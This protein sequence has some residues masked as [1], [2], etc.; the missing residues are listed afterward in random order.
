MRAGART[1]P[2]DAASERRRKFDTLFTTE[3]RYVCGTLRR[4]GVQ[5]RDVEDVAHEVFV[6]IFNKIDTFDVSRP[7][8]PWMLAFAYRAASEY[9]R[10]ARHRREESTGS[11]GRLERAAHATEPPEP[12]TTDDRAVVEEALA[13]VPLDR[14]VVLVAF[15]VDELPMKEIAEGLGIPLAT[16]YSR[17]RHARQD[18]G[19]AVHRARLRR[20][21]AH[22]RTGR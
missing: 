11:E 16:A 18:F 4:L 20:Q 13:A 12:T 2:T 7:A 15:E 14:R 1:V 6:R 17:L 5:E 21:E 19:A 3:L 10:L 8:R 22:E 9:R